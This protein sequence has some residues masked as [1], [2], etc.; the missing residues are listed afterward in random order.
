[1]IYLLI[2]QGARGAIIWTTN[3][4]ARKILKTVVVTAVAGYLVQRHID[5]KKRI[6]GKS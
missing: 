3:H 5:Y 6:N 4:L 2:A 1:M